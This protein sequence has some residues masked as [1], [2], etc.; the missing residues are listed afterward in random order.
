MGWNR[1]G[2]RD[3]D[4]RLVGGRQAQT[5]GLLE[6]AAFVTWNERTE[7]AQEAVGWERKGRPRGLLPG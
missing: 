5:G 7:V 3:G 1:R 6:A 2:D 4:P